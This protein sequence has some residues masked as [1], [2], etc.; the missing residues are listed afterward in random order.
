[1]LKLFHRRERA[2][3]RSSAGRVREAAGLCE[4]L[5]ARQMLAQ[6]TP[7]LD[8]D[9]IGQYTLALTGPGSFTTTTGADGLRQVAL[10]GTTL[11]SNFTISQT[12]AS[13][14]NELTINLINVA[15]DI[16]SITLNEQ[17]ALRAEAGQ[18]APQGIV[19]NG[20]CK[21]IT[22]EGVID[23]VDIQI[24]STAASNRTRMYLNSVEGD[25]NL[26]PEFRGAGGDRVLI[27]SGGFIEEFEASFLTGANLQAARFGAIRIEN[28]LDDGLVGLGPINPVFQGVDVNIT[29]TDASAT[30]G[31]KTI[32]INDGVGTGDWFITA[33]VQKIA[34]E[35]FF[36]DFLLGPPKR[37]FFL[38]DFTLNVVGRVDEL[39]TTQAEM[40]G[41]FNATSFG[42][43]RA[44]TDISNADF[45]GPQFPTLGPGPTFTLKSVD[46]FRAGNQIAD[47]FLN[48][49]AALKQVWASSL[50]NFDL[51]AGWIDT[52]KIGGLMNACDWTID[53]AAAGGG[54][55]S[56]E[57]AGVLLNS[58]I[59][60]LQNN[61]KYASMFGMNNSTFLVGLGG[62]G[63]LPTTSAGIVSGATIETFRLKA[64]AGDPTNFVDSFI[65]AHKIVNIS[66]T[67]KAQTNNGNN[68]FGVAAVIFQNPVSFRGDG[69]TVGVGS[70]QGDLF[71]RDLA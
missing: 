41:Q 53:S 12:G 46:T 54:L 61:V 25:P 2:L 19:V 34:V 51:E 24:S 15:G 42:L 20:R 64:P 57:L 13:G 37:G 38:G 62:I 52:V 48:V 70:N 36:L 26:L 17:V 71:V 21:T 18:S 45:Q 35:R 60:V 56:F 6:T 3:Q 39:R 63:A 44:A 8:T 4:R 55:D 1:M 43:V 67:V 33:P 69:A 65:V 14:D 16:G 5:E 31:V 9:G 23:H 7:I 29:T 27:S 59:H 11:A 50:N 10:T 49:D 22:V 32:T 47:V 66:S 58:N 68:A 30:Y 40:S 28:G